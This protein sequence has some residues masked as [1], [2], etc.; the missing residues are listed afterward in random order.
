MEKLFEDFALPAQLAFGPPPF[1]DVVQYGL[2]CRPAFVKAWHRNDFHA[3]HAAIKADLQLVNLA[4]RYL[5]S[6]R[7]L[8]V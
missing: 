8:D 2:D 7:A 4:P 3:H 5:P 6:S 1:G